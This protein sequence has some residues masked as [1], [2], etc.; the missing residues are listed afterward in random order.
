MNYDFE[1]LRDGSAIRTEEG[2]LLY[3]LVKSIKP[4]ICVETG[5]HQCYSSFWIA[6]A[7][8]EWRQGHLTTCDPFDYDQQKKIDE[9]PFSGQITYKKIAGKDLEVEGLIDFLFVDGFH[10]IND[11]REELDHFLPKLAPHAIVVFHDCDD[12]PRNNSK[13]V[14]AAIFEKKLKTVYIPTANRMRIYEHS[15][16]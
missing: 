9:S 2:L 3:S 13:G 12:E 14:N 5:T 11:V 16:K 6:K 7:L 8:W 1:N 10:E 4:M 15:G